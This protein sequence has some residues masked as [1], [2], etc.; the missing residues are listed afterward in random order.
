MSNR[1]SQSDFSRLPVKDRQAA[2]GQKY[3]RAVELYATTALPLRRVADECGVTA[4]GLSSHIARHHRSL[5]FARYGLDSSSC[6]LNRIK[7]RSPKG[8]SQKTH[9][10]YRDAIEAC[11][12]IAYIE[13][14]MSEIA[15][16][17]GL[18]PAALASQLHAHYPDI[19]PVRE[20]MRR[21]LGIADN[22]SR[23][24]RQTS[25]TGYEE[26]LNLYKD[27]ELTLPEVAER[28]KVSK[29]GFVQYLRF[30]HKD[31]VKKRAARR[32]SACGDNSFNRSGRLSGNGRPYGPR[33]ET[34]AL[35]A[36]ALE[37]YRS[38]S[39][40]LREIAAATGV[41]AGGFRAYV[42]Q[43]H[44]G[45][46]QLR[47]GY[48]WDGVSE[49]DL[50]GTRRFLKSASA[51]YAGAIA[52]LRETP[53]PVAEVAAEF[54][55]NPDVFRAYLR[56]HEPELAACQG[57]TRL[58]DGRRVRQAACEK[59]RAAVREYAASAAPLTDIAQR[60]GLVYGSLSGYVKRNC[61]EEMEQH[62]RAVEAA[63]SG[64]DSE[65]INATKGKVAI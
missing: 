51:K 45:E 9:I 60:H 8:Q 46:T 36:P 3:A 59:Y 18:R 15:R 53:R 56:T 62:R 13:Y 14:N 32:S 42:Q 21:Q 29:G 64:F 31:V 16:L 63:A 47:R 10:K 25:V 61:R 54:G 44:R 19:V 65:S 49:P 23:G 4:A 12:D 30:Y 40:T 22:A 33:P 6:D 43:W 38:S 34:V 58:A 37:L 41:S 17:F 7:V 48:A 39:L 24:A 57:M 27:S 2:A 55:F 28:C 50:S 20:R 1:L 11:G 52:S 35:Y 5:L 26:A